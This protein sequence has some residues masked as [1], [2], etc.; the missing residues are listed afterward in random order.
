MQQPVHCT[1]N[2]PVHCTENNPMHCTEN[3]PVSSTENKPVRPTENKPVVLTETTENNPVALTESNPVTPTKNKP[4]PV[5]TV[6]EGKRGR[7]VL[8]TPETLSDADRT[9]AAELESDYGPDLKAV[10][11]FKER[12]LRFAASNG[13]E[14]GKRE[15]LL[16]AVA[17]ARR[18]GM[19]ASSLST[20]VDG[21][22]QIV[23]IKDGW[24]VRRIASAAHANSEPVQPRATAWN[25]DELKALIC[26]TT[27]IGDAVLLWMLLTTGNRAADVERLTFQQVRLTKDSLIVSWWLRKAQ[28]T[29][30]ERTEQTYLFAWGIPPPKS[31][32]S[33]LTEGPPKHNILPIGACYSLRRVAAH[34][35][36]LVEHL[37]LTSY[38]FRDRMESILAELPGADV[39]GLLDHTARTGAACYRKTPVAKAISDSVLQAKKQTKK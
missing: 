32:R 21:L 16:L 33:F 14:P 30:A 24:Q 38:V 22:L 19:A 34:A 4:V 11:S 7:P 5:E 28:R 25:D 9:F 26:S 15:T 36:S 17:Q 29:R 39:K 13:L 10:L 2:N 37:G 31:V 12:Y 18:M 6:S 8:W 27:V 20:Y 1:E 3:N 35:T 23:P